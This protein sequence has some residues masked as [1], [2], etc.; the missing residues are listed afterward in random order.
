MHIH[1]C[2]YLYFHIYAYM[3]ICV[4]TYI[5]IYTYVQMWIH[6]SYRE[7]AS[8]W[9]SRMCITDGCVGCLFMK[10]SVR[11]LIRFLKQ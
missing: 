3:Y 4:C 6:N 7:G 5:N 1:I 2:I 9:H 11:H 8:R 10:K